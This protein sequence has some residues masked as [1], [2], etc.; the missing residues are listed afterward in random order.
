MSAVHA[1]DV[2]AAR[3]R[4]FSNWFNGNLSIG[5]MASA[6][7]SLNS[8]LGYSPFNRAVCIASCLLVVKPANDLRWVRVNQEGTHTRVFSK[9]VQ[10]R[11]FN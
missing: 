2:R 1:P 10:W 6:V 8:A 7:C 3:A 4:V 11:I 5:S 9:L